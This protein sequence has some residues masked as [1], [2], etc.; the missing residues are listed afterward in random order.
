M[1]PSRVRNDIRDRLWAVADK[2]D[3]MTLP[4][5][6]RSRKYEEWTRDGD[7]GGVLGN[8]LDSK[9]VRVYIKDS[10]MK[11]YIRVRSSD[12]IRPL[13]AA[14][15]D[16]FMVSIETYIKP[17]G[18]RLSDGSV[19]CWGQA[20]EW[21]DVLVA[22]WER[23]YENRA[24]PRAAVLTAASGKWAGGALRAK[25]EDLARRLGVPSLIWLDT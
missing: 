4:D 18:R 7:I 16:E 6:A 24:V 3:W 2:I 1:I 15:V 10:I 23:A 5:S 14:G 25:A 12:E 9:R 22:A 17:H 13:R 20:R 19:V 8:Y 11:P 21:K